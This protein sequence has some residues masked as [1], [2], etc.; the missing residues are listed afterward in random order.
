MVVSSSVFL[1]IHPM[2]AG[3][4][5]LAPILSLAISVLVSRCGLPCDA[6]CGTQSLSPRAQPS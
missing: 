1:V 6:G 5:V 3:L 2:A 4:S